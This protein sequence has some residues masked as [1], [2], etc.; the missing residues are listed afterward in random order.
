MIQKSITLVKNIWINHKRKIGSAIIAVIILGSVSV[1]VHAMFQ[2]KGVITGIDDNNVTVANFFRTQTVNLAG[3]PVKLST[4]K[5]GDRIKIQKNLQGDIIYA[6]TLNGKDS[7]H[8]HKDREQ[9]KEYRERI[10]KEE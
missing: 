7:E 3:A 6:K 5:V 4:I 8:K 1:G 9:H 10:E 2:V